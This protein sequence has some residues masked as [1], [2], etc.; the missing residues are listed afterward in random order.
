MN[1]KKEK[2]L[3]I[4]MDLTL[5]LNPFS[6]LAMEKGNLSSLTNLPLGM[7]D[8]GESFAMQK[9][10]LVRRPVLGHKLQEPVHTLSRQK[11]LHPTLLGQHGKHGAFPRK[12]LFS[13][14]SEQQPR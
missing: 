11:V 5:R 13:E 3:V 8:A 9:M 10:T 2:A 7:D 4:W 6:L 14:S 12:Q 1:G